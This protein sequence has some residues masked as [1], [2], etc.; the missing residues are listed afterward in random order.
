[1]ATTNDFAHAWLRVREFA[2]I[3][4]RMRNWTSDTTSANQLWAA[5][6]S[7]V[8][9]DKCTFDPDIQQGEEVALIGQRALV[10]GLLTG[11]RSLLDPLMLQLSRAMGYPQTNAEA[12][13]PILVKYMALNEGSFK[14][15]PRVN[16]RAFS[17][18]SW[19]A[20]GSNQG[21]GT[22]LRQVVDRYDLPLEHD[23]P[24]VYK[25]LCQL[26]AN[27]GTNVGAEQFRVTG[28]PFRDNLSRYLT[29]YGI[30]IGNNIQA[31]NLVGVEGQQTRAYIQNP[32]FSDFSGTGASATFALTSWTTVSGMA[33]AAQVDTAQYYRASNVESTAGSLRVSATSAIKQKIPA[34]Q[35]NSTLCYMAQAACNFSAGG[36][37]GSVRMRIGTEAAYLIDVTVNSGVAG[38]NTIR[39]TIDKKLYAANFVGTGDVYVRFDITVSS[40]SYILLDDFCFAPFQSIGGKLF[41]AIGGATNWVVNDTGTITDTVTA[42]NGVPTTANVQTMFAEVYGR[43]LP[44]FALTTAP[45]G[46]AIARTVGGTGANGVVGCVVTFYNGTTG[47]ESKA[48]AQLTVTLDGTNDRI[49]LSSIPTGPAG[50]TDRYVYVT[51][52]NDYNA[53]NGFPSAAGPESAYYFAAALGDN[54]ATTKTVD[55]LASIDLTKP[56]AVLQDI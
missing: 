15:A 29:G 19:T 30:G 11:G 51:Q 54:V 34:G 40:G 2:R 44:A 42:T 23:S 38:W 14:S 5:L 48:S 36:A 18:G 16:S 12:V 3:W 39:P 22:V 41:W 43:S 24:D 6:E 50:T 49:S 4:Y 17:R 37:T 33:A 9:A 27:T 8:R 46:T 28:A 47:A 25:F 10:A 32:S 35:L 45:V 7:V 52:L 20:G 53:T 1:M 55:P 13:I 31:P 21:N 56:L 26:D